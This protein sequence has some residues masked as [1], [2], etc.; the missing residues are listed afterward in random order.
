M[1]LNGLRRIVQYRGH[2]NEFVMFWVTCIRQPGWRMNR[3][4]AFLADDLGGCDVD[5][6]LPT[7]GTLQEVSQ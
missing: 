1:V 4:V 5:H 6:V 3:H 7:F 2:P